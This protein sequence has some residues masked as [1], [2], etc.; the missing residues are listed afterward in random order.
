VVATFFTAIGRIAVRSRWAIVAAWAAGLVA[1]MV[2]LPSLSSV[3]QGDNTSFLPASAPSQQAAQLAAPLQGA[4][5]TAV[6]VV[7]A[8]LAGPLTSADQAEIT[9]LQ[10]ALSRLPKVTA[11]RDAGESADGRAEQLTV[12]AALAQSGGL[13]TTQQ[14]HLVGDLRA[15][16][17]AAGRHSSQPAASPAACRAGSR[18]TWPGRWRPGWTATRCPPRRAAS[19]SGSRSS[20]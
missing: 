13:S 5:L 6:T 15:V 9:R 18:R 2:L 19:C 7:A 3:T 4:S 14:A 16:I 20:S 12:L 10:A 1:A 17:R 11:V 8:R